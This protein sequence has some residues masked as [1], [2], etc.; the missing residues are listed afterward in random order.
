M[1]VVRQKAKAYKICFPVGTLFLTSGVLKLHRAPWVLVESSALNKDKGPIWD[2][3][4]G[5]EV[6]STSHFLS[7]QF[8]WKTPLPFLVIFDV[9]LNSKI[10][11]LYA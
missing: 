3:A 5:P 1:K 10:Y 7:V 9:Y 4:P 8:V 2:A 6:I 11:I